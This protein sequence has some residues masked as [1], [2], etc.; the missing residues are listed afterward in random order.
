[1]KTSPNDANPTPQET[2]EEPRDP[3]PFAQLKLADVSLWDVVDI[4]WNERRIAA[5]V[6]AVVL[7]AGVFAAWT[8]PKTYAS[9]TRLIVLYDDAYVLDPMVAPA[10]TNASF[11]PEEMVRS[12]VAVLTS[13][14][15]K[16]RAI[17]SLG[18]AT[19]YPALADNKNKT[20]AEGL[21]VRRMGKAM[22]VEIAPNSPSVTLAFRH[23]NA[24]TAAAVV[25]AL[26]DAFLSYRR[27]LLAGAAT[28][29]LIAERAAAETRL[30]A[31]DE[32]LAQFRVEHGVG[33]LAAERAAV[34]ARVSTIEDELYRV[35]ALRA[36]AEA[37]L[38]S[39]RSSRGRA[40][41]VIALQVDDSAAGR[42]QEL[43]IERAELL[44]RYLPDSTPVREIEARIA[45]LEAQTGSGAID[46]GLARRGPNPVH[47]SLDGDAARVGAE[48]AALKAKE[49]ALAAQLAQVRERQIALQRLAPEH[50]RLERSRSA[51]EGAVDRLAAR[52]ESERTR[53]AVAAGASDAIRVI[54]RAAPSVQ[55]S[56]MRRPAA[57]F[58]LVLAVFAAVAAA[59][60]S[61][62]RDA[63]A[64]PK[65]DVAVPRARTF[66]VVGGAAE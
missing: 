23:K 24:D 36:E 8:L 10:N 7:L 49:G 61:A 11:S 47:Q 48:V 27:E 6:G 55:A 34:Q 15:L 28:E 3:R 2:R 39:I 43:K 26:V 60:I 38:G 58:A 44:T 40:P 1:M 66:A 42:L 22:K 25:N 33:D 65:P 59:L 63:F 19:I 46:G 56:S 18:L 16:R 51:L 4:V 41:E 53:R 45:E 32:A 14:T 5:M 64:A 20:R 50:D 37:R 52:E 62:W 17:E 13:D 21:A 35:Q 31:A 57:A 12:E 29:G 9:A 30:A 54:E